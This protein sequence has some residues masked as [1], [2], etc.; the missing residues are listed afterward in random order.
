[1]TW[2]HDLIMGVLLA[3]TAW[4]LKQVWTDLNRRVTRLEKITDHLERRS[5]PRADGSGLEQVI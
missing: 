1:M 5:T 4:S 2:D 3:L